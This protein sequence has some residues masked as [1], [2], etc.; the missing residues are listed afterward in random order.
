MFIFA[1]TINGMSVMTRKD[2]EIEVCAY[3]VESCRNALA[4]GA[5]RVELCAGMWDGGV[6]PSGG[7]VRE[8]KR[9]GIP[10]FVMIRPRGGDF[11]YT[12]DEFAVM[13]EDVMEAKR[14]GADGVVTGVLLA[15]GN[16][17]VERTRE[18]ARLAAPL[19]V[20]FHR[21]I[22]MTP[23]VEEALE[24]V[25]AAGCRRVLTSGGRNTAVEGIEGLR[26]MARRAAG[27]IKVMAGS[28]VNG[29]NAGMLL[30]AGV[31]ALHL[32]GRASRDSGM[33]FR[34]PE[35][36]M[37]GMPGIPEYEQYYSAVE[38]VAAVVRVKRNFE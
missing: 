38:K 28:G 30:E 15:D 4:A 20:T 27:R 37:G 36:S 3:S 16:V 11:L 7:M 19:P 35:V 1:K 31:D 24:R 9:C 5:D 18:L 25:I 23:D 10:V 6:T 22:D 26:R 33:V 29:G 12:E 8:A 17:D 2:I 13:R 14:N 34:N 21:A 32:S